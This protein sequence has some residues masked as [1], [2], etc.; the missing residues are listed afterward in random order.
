MHDALQELLEL[1]G[2]LQADSINLPRDRRLISRQLESFEARK[3]VDGEGEKFK[4]TR[5]NSEGCMAS[6]EQCL[7]HKMLGEI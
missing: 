1:S 4:I 3:E 7:S 5:V 6:L 2:S